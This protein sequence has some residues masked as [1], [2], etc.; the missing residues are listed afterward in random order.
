MD[1]IDNHLFEDPSD[2]D[3]LQGWD[4]LTE[5]LVVTDELDGCFNPII[6]PQ[7]VEL[8]LKVLEQVLYLRVNI[9]NDVK[10]DK[11]FD[12]GLTSGGIVQHQERSQS[13]FLLHG[14]FICLQQLI[15]CVP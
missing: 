1:Y 7:G 12:E 3:L 4:V 10:L 15:Y 13:S 9:L 6:Q 11:V 14:C 8:F 5:F 2:D